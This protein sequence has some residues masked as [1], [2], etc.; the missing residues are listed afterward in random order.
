M[1]YYVFVKCLYVEQ[2][3]IRTFPICPTG[4]LEISKFNN[5]LQVSLK[6]LLIKNIETKL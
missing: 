2:H 4:Y 6:Y 5:F 3:I 1:L